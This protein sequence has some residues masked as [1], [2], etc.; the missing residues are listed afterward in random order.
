MVHISHVYESGANLYI[1]FLSP[2][3]KGNER[4]DFA[5]FHSGLVDTVQENGG[6]LSHHHGVG[7]I[8]SPWM[9]K[10]LG[11]TSVAVMAAVKR[12]FDPYNIMNPN[13]ILGL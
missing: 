10:H 4:N 6:S 3:E 7:R 5:R 13:K 2:M 12:H 11:N 8:L 1:T 9:E